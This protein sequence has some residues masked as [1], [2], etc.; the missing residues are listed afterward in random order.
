MEG[1]SD[2]TVRPSLAQMFLHVTQC[3]MRLMRG[4]ANESGSG[5]GSGR[6]SGEVGGNS[7]PPCDRVLS[8]EIRSLSDPTNE[9]VQRRCLPIHEGFRLCL[10]WFP[11]CHGHNCNALVWPVRKHFG[12]AMPSQNQAWSCCARAGQC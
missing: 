2:A 9:G 11:A 12:S 3:S 1:V 10:V 4:T 8:V 5:E 6:G 7:S